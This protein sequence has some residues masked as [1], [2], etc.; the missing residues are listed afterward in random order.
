MSCDAQPGPLGSVGYADGRIEDAHKLAVG[1]S[2]RKAHIKHISSV[3]H[4][5]HLSHP[6]PQTP[7]RGISK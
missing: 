5:R 2:I 1:W 6:G 4:R 7:R 3:P